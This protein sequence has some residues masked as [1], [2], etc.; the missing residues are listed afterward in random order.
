MIK[1][2]KIKKKMKKIKIIINI[3][4]FV[5]KKKEVN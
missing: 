1:K 3:Y 4:E 2:L 5:M